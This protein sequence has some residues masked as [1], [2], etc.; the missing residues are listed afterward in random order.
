VPYL[1]IV[2]R[3]ASMM[4]QFTFSLEIEADSEVDSNSS[5]D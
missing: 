4:I 2:R 1:K 5:L 3:L